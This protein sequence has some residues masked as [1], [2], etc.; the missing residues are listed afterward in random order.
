[1]DNKYF[2]EGNGNLVC[3]MCDSKFYIIDS[4]NVPVGIDRCCVNT[5]TEWQNELRKKE[6]MKSPIGL[7]PAYIVYEKRIVEINGAI[8][9]FI[10]AQKEIPYEWIKEKALIEKYMINLKIS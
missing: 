10:E 7:M 8:E 9:R 6:L 3:P 5:I 1:M 4:R 2:V